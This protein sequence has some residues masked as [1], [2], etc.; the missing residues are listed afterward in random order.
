M[1]RVVETYK[2]NQIANEK[3]RLLQERGIDSRILVD[4]LE[5]RF[6]GLADF[7]DVA[8][9]VTDLKLAEASQ[10]LDVAAVGKRR[11]S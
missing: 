4:P 8:L 1:R 6:P 11:A 7:Q 10:I 2:T 3:R 9:M 5:G